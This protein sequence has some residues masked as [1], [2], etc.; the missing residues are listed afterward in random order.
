[1]FYGQKYQLYVIQ[2]APDLVR[3][4]V[5]NFLT[6]PW[7]GW[8]SHQSKDIWGWA[9]NAGFVNKFVHHVRKTLNIRFLCKY[10]G[11][12]WIEYFIVTCDKPQ[13]SSLLTYKICKYS[14]IK[15]AYK[16]EN[17]ANRNEKR[18]YENVLISDFYV[19]VTECEIAALNLQSKINWKSYLCNSVWF[20]SA[21]LIFKIGIFKNRYCNI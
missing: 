3:G 1:M 19:K 6:A 13:C 16:V 20:Y 4:N 8:A 18:N 10:V 11:L 2:S 5:L 14:S 21:I 17:V 15:G 7:S 12:N 9:K